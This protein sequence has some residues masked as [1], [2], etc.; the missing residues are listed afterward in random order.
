MPLRHFA[1]PKIA[2]N[3]SI[4]FSLKMHALKHSHAHPCESSCLFQNISS[5]LILDSVPCCCCWQLLI[6]IFFCWREGI[7][8]LCFGMENNSIYFYKDGHDIKMCISKD[9]LM[10][11]DNACDIV[12]DKKAWHKTLQS[13]NSTV[14]L[15]IAN[16]NWMQPD[17]NSLPMGYTLLHYEVNEHCH[18]FFRDKDSDAQ[19]D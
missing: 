8:N 3:Y 17:L 18:S 16:M 7:F 2:I 12:N 9:F 4:S 1:L 14:I 6:Q 19:K 15:T 5:Y 11:R 13:I 10:T